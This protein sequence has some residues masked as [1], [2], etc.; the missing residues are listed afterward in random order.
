MQ[1][2]G[3]I[4]KDCSNNWTKIDYFFKLIYQVVIG[5]ST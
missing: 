5:G 4:E 3:A 2:I 1:M